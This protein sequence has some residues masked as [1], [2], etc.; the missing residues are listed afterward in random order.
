MP[1]LKPKPKSQAY[2][3]DSKHQDPLSYAGIWDAHTVARWRTYTRRHMYG[4]LCIVCCLLACCGSNPHH[5]NLTIQLKA[6][7]KLSKTHMPYPPISGI[8]PTP[9]PVPP[10][11]DLLYTGI[12]LGIGYCFHVLNR[13]MFLY[14]P[15]VEGQPFT[16]LI[17]RD[18]FGFTWGW[19]GPRLDDGVSGYWVWIPSHR[20]VRICWP[21]GEPHSSIPWPFQHGF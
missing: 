6:Q 11:V 8:H 14:A 10:R 9:P 3:V 18:C 13:P 7:Q 19:W 16:G 20:Q 2:T 4:R 5:G 12:E 1:S 21:L 15:I 17:V